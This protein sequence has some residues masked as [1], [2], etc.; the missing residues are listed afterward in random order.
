MHCEDNS[1]S[2]FA[3]PPDTSLSRSAKHCCDRHVFERYIAEC[4]NLYH[5]SYFRAGMQEWLY[6]RNV[7]FQKEIRILSVGF[8]ISQSMEGWGT[9]TPKVGTPLLFWSIV[10]KNCMKTKRRRVWGLVLGYPLG[11][12]N[13][14]DQMTLCALLHVNNQF[15]NR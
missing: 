3:P 12:A 8:K 10:P 9:L 1:T 15:S 6:V 13:E 2:S 5:V 11:S 7:A 14:H 4:S